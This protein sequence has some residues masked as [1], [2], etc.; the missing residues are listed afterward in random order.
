MSLEAGRVITGISFLSEMI[1]ETRDP[2]TK[3][4]L[5]KRLDALKII[6]FLEN[7][8]QEYEQK[9]NRSPESLADLVKSEIIEKIPE[10][11][12]GGNFYLTGNGR[13]YTT[14]RLAQIQKKP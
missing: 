9:F 1:H 3:A 14:S 10:D 4:F 2:Q 6:Y 5:Q 8:V 12:Y 11:P 13:V 7:K